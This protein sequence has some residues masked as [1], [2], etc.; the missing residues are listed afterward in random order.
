M[1]TLH[2]A[3]ERRSHQLIPLLL[4]VLCLISS[5]VSGQFDSSFN[6]LD[7]KQTIVMRLEPQP[8]KPNFMQQAQPPR[9]V[10]QHVSSPKQEE[11]QVLSS[12]AQQMYRPNNNNSPQTPIVQESQQKIVRTVNSP[13]VGAQQPILPAATQQQVGGATSQFVPRETVTLAPAPPMNIPPDVQNQ[14]IKFFGLDSFG[15]PGLTGNHPNGFAG[16]VQVN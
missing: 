3:V 5:L 9:A 11:Q 14:L 6:D 12:Q 15:I 7:A 8:Q 10:P 13:P 16:A 2:S 4:I 1:L